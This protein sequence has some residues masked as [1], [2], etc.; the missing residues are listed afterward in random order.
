V[1]AALA[2]S[3]SIDH[4][5]GWSIRK[6][7]KTAR[8]CRTIQIQAGIYTITAADSLADDLRQDL[9]AIHGTR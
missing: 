3:R 4:Q 8:R 5:A 1:F 6:I 9:D 2:A 7:V